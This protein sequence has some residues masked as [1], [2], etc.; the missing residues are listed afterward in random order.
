M[1]INTDD[2][3]IKQNAEKKR[4]EVQVGEH[5]AFLEYMPAGKN[6]IYPHT[7]V[8]SE[9]EGHGIGN[10]LAH[11]AM[12][13]AKANGLKVQALCPFVAAYVRKHPEYQDI[14]W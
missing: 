3:E 13:Y 14:T 6:I 2:L 9:L 10:K 11:H 8:P 12:E 1:D 5:I 7:E 4:F